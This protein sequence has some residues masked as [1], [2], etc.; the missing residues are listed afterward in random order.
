MGA[1]EKSQ[2]PSMPFLIFEY[3]YRDASNYKV[4]GSLILYGQLSDEEQTE[5]VQCLESGEF[6]VAEQVGVPPLYSALFQDGGGPTEDD[7]AW[8]MFD[9]FRV[10]TASDQNDEIWG[11]VT[12]FLLRFRKAK[13]CW[14]P[15]L[16]PNF[17]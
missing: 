15:E 11:S 16:S 1:D 7:H 10:G 5:F 2:T 14:Q 12:D 8:H 13:Q 17:Q 9:Q 4:F 3:L 6:F